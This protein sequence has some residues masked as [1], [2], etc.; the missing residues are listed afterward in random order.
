MNRVKSGIVTFKV[1]G[2][3]SKFP[4]MTPFIFPLVTQNNFQKEFLFSHV[5][6]GVVLLKLVAPHHTI[7]RPCVRCPQLRFL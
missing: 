3:I 6:R 2:T 7:L 4:Q 1:L 5:G